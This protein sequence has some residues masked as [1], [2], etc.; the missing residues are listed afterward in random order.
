MNVEDVIP[1]RFY[2]TMI[3]SE[4]VR[5]WLRSLSFQERKN[6]GEDI[7]IVQLSWPIGM[8]LVKY[9][10]DGLYEIRSS[11]PTNKIARIVF[12]MHKNEI[13]LL[14][15]FIKKTNKIELNELKLAKKR[16]KEVIN[17]EKKDKI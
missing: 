13:I 5:E 6:L 9:I 2:A 17:H 11:L 8:P 1:V 3:G 12:F 10:D 4:P 15:G 14:H 7:K 16:K